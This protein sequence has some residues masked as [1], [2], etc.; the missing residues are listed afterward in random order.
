VDWAK[1]GRQKVLQKAVATANCNCDEVMVSQFYRE[2]KSSFP[3][4]YVILFFYVKLP[5]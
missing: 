1:H 3:Q 2:G 4:I 5:S